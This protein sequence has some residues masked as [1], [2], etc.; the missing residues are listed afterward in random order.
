VTDPPL[1]LLSKP[2]SP[3]EEA[4]ARC[5]A[6]GLSYKRIAAALDMSEHTAVVYV[7][8]IDAKIPQPDP[9]SD[10]LTPYQRV[11]V[12]AYWRWH[13]QPVEGKATA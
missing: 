11:L 4:V 13:A 7:R 9:D 5:V 1:P 12:W 3:R 2:L 10:E 8:R 6:R